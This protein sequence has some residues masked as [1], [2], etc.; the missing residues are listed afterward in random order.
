ML[1]KRIHPKAQIHENLTGYAVIAPALVFVITFFILPLSVTFCK[2]FT[3]WNGVVTKFV[4]FEN[5]RRLFMEDIFWN[6][7]FNN[8]LILLSIPFQIIGGLVAAL[9]LYQQ[10]VG[11]RF[12]R[13]VYYIP[14]IIA[15]IVAGY[16]FRTAFSLNGPINYILTGMGLDPV[17]WLGNQFTGIIVICIVLF[18]NNFGT[19]VLIFLAGLSAIHPAIFEASTIDGASWWKQFFHIVLPMLT[20]VI[21]FFSVTTIIWTFTG[22]F[23]FVYSITGGGPG[24]STA[25]LDYYIYLKAFN[26]M[27]EI[28]YACALA[29]ILFIIVF[30]ISRAQIA[31]SERADDWGE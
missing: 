22:I 14:V 30:F 9:L 25:P 11:W 23:P 20:R 3:D 8:F 16:L 26:S 28:G 17:E 2:S 29:F 31:L 1:P 15:A 13:A 12:F 21:E 27:T 10:V 24:Y 19:A 4:G 5:Y 7:L 18:W 6:S